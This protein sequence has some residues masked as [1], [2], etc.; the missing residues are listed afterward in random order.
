ML[1]GVA[2]EVEAE[3][4]TWLAHRRVQKS[5]AQIEGAL[6][7]I[8]VPERLLLISQS[9]QNCHQ[10]QQQIAQCDLCTEKQLAQIADC[11]NPSQAS[12]PRAQ[13]PASGVE[14]PRKTEPQDALELS[15]LRNQHGEVG[16][17]QKPWSPGWD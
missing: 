1:Y 13:S 5:R 6:S 9:L 8:T 10:T 11:T 3:K 2:S 7:A 12:A 4:D 15:D 16:A 17:T 14:K